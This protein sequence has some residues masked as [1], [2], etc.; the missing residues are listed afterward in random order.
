ME[1]KLNARNE[2][3]KGQNVLRS[4]AEREAERAAKKNAQQNNVLRF[5]HLVAENKLI[6]GMTPMH[7]E[8]N[9]FAPILREAPAEK[10]AEI[11]KH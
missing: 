8:V 6:Q 5:V 10:R 9:F 7:A 3:A 4:A 11:K 1:A 2:A